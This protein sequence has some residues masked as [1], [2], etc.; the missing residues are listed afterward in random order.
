MTHL[1]DDVMTEAD[2]RPIG[3]YPTAPKPR[4]VEPKPEAN[5]AAGHGQDW[6]DWQP[7]KFNI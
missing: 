2:L 5:V 1:T 7:R 4:V 3:P 6:G